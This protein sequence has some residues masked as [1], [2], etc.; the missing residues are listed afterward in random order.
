MYYQLGAERPGDEIKI[1]A[2]D[3]IEVVD[4]TVAIRDAAGTVLEE[5]RAGKDHGI[6]IHRAT[7]A[8]SGAQ[9]VTITISARNRAG[10]T[11][12]SPRLTPEA[13]PKPLNRAESPGFFQ[14]AQ[15]LQVDPRILVARVHAQGGL[16]F[17]DRVVERAGLVEELREVVV[18]DGQIRFRAQGRAIVGDRFVPPGFRPR[19]LIRE[20]VMRLGEIRPA[21]NGSR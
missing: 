5:A 15:T 1:M 17:A 7:S 13:R 20:I 12:T 9:A 18:R 10:A 4:V 2:S 6:W 3:A 8:L 21:A 16:E 19:Q 14:C 11:A